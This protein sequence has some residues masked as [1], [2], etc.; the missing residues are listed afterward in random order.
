MEFINILVIGRLC[1]D[2]YD[3]VVT[4]GIIGGGRANLHSRGPE[5]SFSFMYS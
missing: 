3:W 5:L 1:T 4:S 2:T